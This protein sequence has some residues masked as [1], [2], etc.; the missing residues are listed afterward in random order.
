VSA[1]SFAFTAETFCVAYDTLIGALGAKRPLPI[2]FGQKVHPLLQHRAVLFGSGAGQ[3]VVDAARALALQPHLTE[4]EDLV[5]VLPGLLGELARG[6]AEQA[7]LGD[8]RPLGLLRTLLAGWSEREKRFRLWSFNNF[9]DDFAAQESL[10]MGLRVIPDIVDF[11]TVELAGN[12]IGEQLVAA[13][14][15][16]NDVLR[17]DPEGYHGLVLGGEIHALEITQAGFCHRVLH[18]FEDYDAVRVEAAENVRR[19]LRDGDWP[20]VRDGIVPVDDFVGLR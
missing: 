15:A 12:N 17:A 3:I 9:E 10:L 14:L 2:G 4:L 16:M 13:L 1:F 18:R 19:L 5:K 6:F 8:H 20:A 7:A 11:D